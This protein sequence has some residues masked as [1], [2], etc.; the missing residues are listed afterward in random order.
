VVAGSVI[1][2]KVYGDVNPLSDDV[3]VVNM[4][5]G[6]RVTKSGIIL[7]DDNGKPWG[8][9]PRWAQVYKV[10]KNIDWLEPGQFIL[11]EHGKWSYGIEMILPDGGDDVFY[12]Q[13]VDTDGILVVSDE[14]PD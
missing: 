13:K 6:G 11:I 12:L 3:L 9:R 2:Q 4:E 8:I 10:G 1:Y 14:Q 5:K 7:L